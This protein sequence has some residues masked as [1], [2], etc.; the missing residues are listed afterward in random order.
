MSDPKI[1]NSNTVAPQTLKVET[2]DQ[3]ID[4][5]SFIG[6]SPVIKNNISGYPY[7]TFFY[8]KADG[9]RGFECVWFSKNGAAV[10]KPGN[11]TPEIM[12]DVQIVHTVNADGEQRIKASRIS[13][14]EMIDLK[15]FMPKVE[16]AREI[17]RA[18]AAADE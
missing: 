2:L 3:F 16:T 14:S 6:M 4:R 17:A 13:V 1:A 18:M 11:I 10:T 8:T 15:S 7:I 9:T 12:A 5:N